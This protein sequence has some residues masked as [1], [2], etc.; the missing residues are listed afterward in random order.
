[1]IK[2]IK[3]GRSEAY[4]SSISPWGG[5]GTDEEVT[6]VVTYNNYLG[7]CVERYSENTVDESR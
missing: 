2:G 5:R 3:K 4:S 1:M 6:S 7:N